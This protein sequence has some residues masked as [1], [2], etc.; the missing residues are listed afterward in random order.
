MNEHL[1][2]NNFNKQKKY[3]FLLLFALTNILIYGF[4][5]DF[6]FFLFL[7]IVLIYVYKKHIPYKIILI[8]FHIALIIVL[9]KFFINDFIFFDFLNLSL[10]KIFNINLRKRIIDG[11]LNFYDEYGSAMISL[12]IFNI[13]NNNI[14][15]EI[16]QNINNMSITYLIVIGGFQISFINIVIKKIIKNKKYSY[17]FSLLITIIFSYF[18]NFSPSIMRVLMCLILT[19][20]FKNIKN[21]YDI[22]S[23]SGLL[24]IISGP[25]CMFNYGF[26]MSYACSLIIIYISEQQ[27][28]NYFIEKIL[29][30]IVTVLITLPFVALMNKNISL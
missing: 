4:F 1:L 15:W 20:I 23:L 26:C 14:S 11:I 7:L 3:H 5:K 8:Y 24:I 17:Y 12:T 19:K 27:I 22:V 16:Y 29:I 2:L 6:Y 10:D 28:N 18:L 30:D 25:E 9:I 13:K 21:K